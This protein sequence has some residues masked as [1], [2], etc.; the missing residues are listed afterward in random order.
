MNF[1]MT[2]AAR[3]LSGRK[4]RTFLTTLAIVIGVMVIF[5]M[6]IL[7]PSMMGAFNASLLAASGQTDVMITH[8]TG[9]NFSATV[10]N[11]IKTLD[12]I[13]VIAG[14]LERTINLP[15]NFYGKDSTVTALS[16]VGIDPAAAPALHDYRVTQGRFLKAGDGN[17]VVISERLADSIGVT[18]NGTI[19]LPT[20]EG[21]IKLTV[22]G[23][24]PGRALAGNEQVLIT[25]SQAQ[26]LLDAAGRINVIEANLTTKDQAQSDAIVAKIQALLGDTYTL[27][28]LTSGSEFATTM[29]NSA[30]IFNM[31]G[32]LTLAMGGFIIFNTFRTIVA[33][34]RHDIGMLRA[35]G[36]NRRTIISL[37]LTEGLVQGVIGTAIGIGLGYLL[38]AGIMTGMNSFLKS[39]M[40]IEMT[41]VADPSLYVISIVLGVGVTLLAG[42]LPALNASR[43]TPMEALRPSLGET[44]Q[45]ISRAGT[46]IGVMMLVVAV[47]GLFTRI[48]EL[49][50][51][52]GLLVLVGL[53]LVAPALVKPIARLFGVALALVFAREGT[54]ELA[55]GNLTRQPSRAA[56]TASATMIGLAIVVGA[57][58][59]IFSLTGTAMGMFNRSLGSDYLLV[60]PSVA[61]WK[62]DVGASET[63]KAKL[64]AIPGVG[65]VNSLRYAQSSVQ[66]VSMKTG[67]GDTTISVLGI[68]PVEYA[69][70]S[71]M[72]FVSG[73]AQDA[74]TALAANERNIIV[75]GILATPLGLKV[76]DVIPLATPTGRQNYR[77]V[78][79]GSDVLSLKINTAYISQTNMKLDFNKSEDI[80]YQINLAP[81]A[82]VA[83]VE[84]WLNQIVAD[85]PQF[86]LVSGHEYLAEFAQQYD[87]IIWGFYVLLAVL[88]FPSLIA[89]LNTLAISVIERTREIGML[90]A[91]GATRRQVWR[92]I[93]AEALLLAALGTAFGILA[94]LYLSYV[95]VEGLN[96]AGYMKMD[97]TFPFA[98]VLAA[99]AAGLIFGVL[100]ALM[101][102]RQASSMQI[103][104]ALRYE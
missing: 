16:L 22:V 47:V 81:G 32:F 54:G 57:G 19:K 66:S 5:G 63:L 10:L 2:L 73:N 46:V 97:Y 62:G 18:L 87:A 17:V 88:A 35:I 13:A 28:G 29:Q 83:T 80:L 101:P 104:E 59:M 12:G 77:I 38:G 8:T 25:L 60:P 40:N 49:V 76:G 90:R 31:I 4:L 85:Y 61:I 93:V 41:P 7:L 3:Y 1:Q 24:M 68:D 14:S 9:E 56:I 82:D 79:I 39:L 42:L 71:G 34:R 20:T 102:A 45:R 98:G 43:V 11:K 23:L 103:I 48:F 64:R 33:E 74:F 95:F 69:K 36:A 86:R 91:I 51:L 50:A 52:G 70:L 6:G 26:K 99:I 37:V 94:G 44:M 100:A 78:A 27:G 21:V 72:D 84:Q 96:A 65:A 15:P 67:T 75:N 58:G 53:A 92:T 30:V 55:Q 89:I